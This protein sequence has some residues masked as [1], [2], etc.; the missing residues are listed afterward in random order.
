MG[1]M[2]QAQVCS[3]LPIVELGLVL[4]SMLR[5]LCEQTAGFGVLPPPAS[6]QHHSGMANTFLAQAYDL[7]DEWSGERGP[8]VAVGWNHSSPE[9]AC[10][11]N[12]GVNANLSTC[13]PAWQAK[14]AHMCAANA[15]TRFVLFLDISASFHAEKTAAQPIHGGDS[16][17]LQDLRRQTTC[18]GMRQHR[19]RWQSLVH[20]PDARWLSTRQ[21]VTESSYLGRTACNSDLAHAS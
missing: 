18:E 7:N 19:L 10:C 15:G 8:C 13:P 12:H 14:C 4:H 9:H 2:R 3:I 11:D 5:R 17:A 21:Y 1:A 20:R 16:P 6:N